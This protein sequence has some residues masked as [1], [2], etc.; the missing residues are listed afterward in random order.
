MFIR[1][2]SG[3][4]N[5]STGVGSGSDSAGR[6]TRATSP[7]TY[8]GAY[9]GVNQG[10]AKPD[11]NKAKQN[12]SSTPNQPRRSLFQKLSGSRGTNQMPQPNTEAEAQN[13][14][15]KTEFEKGGKGRQDFLRK[16]GFECKSIDL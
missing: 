15:T 7:T 4:Q 16:L 9:V 5:T 14:K 10:F 13:D 11:P 8:G 3:E 12:R 1:D 6:K 2:G